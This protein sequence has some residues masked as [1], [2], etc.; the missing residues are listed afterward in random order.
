ML[1]LNWIGKES[2][3]THH[4][5]LLSGVRKF[6]IILKVTTLSAVHLFGVLPRECLVTSGLT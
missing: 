2:I 4:T 5:A 1:S 3:I 6:A